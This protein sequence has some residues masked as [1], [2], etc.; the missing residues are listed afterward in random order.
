MRNVPLFSTGMKC[1]LLLGGLFLLTPAFAQTNVNLR[2]MAANLNGDTQSYQP[3]AIRILQGTKADVVA[4]QEFNYTSTNGLGVNTPAAM[5]EMIDTAFG[6]NYSYYREP[7]TG[8]GD[9]PNG[10]ISRYPIIAAGSW[11]D[12]EQTQPNRGFAWAQIDVPGTN[13]LY[14]VSVHLLTST[15][16]HRANESAALKALMQANFPANAWAVVAGDFNAGSRTEA[17]VTTYNGYLTDFPIPVDNNG[18]SLTSGGRSAPHDYVLPSLTLT[19]F[20][21]ATVFPSH[22][23]PTGLVFDS[24]VYT[25]LSDAAPV[26][27]ADS[28][29]AQH[30]AVMKDFLIPAGGTVSTNVIPPAITTQPQGQTNAVGA[31]ITFGVTA[32]G[33]SP[34]AYQWRFGT[35]NISGA[36][37]NPF[38]IANAQLTNNGNYFVVITN[39]AGS[40]TSS[41]A[42]LLTTN[43]PPAITSQPQSQT[44]NLG[45]SASFGV[46]ASGTS[47]L[48]YQWLFGGTNIVGA[49]TNPFVVANVQLTNAGN[50]SVVVS[51]FVGSATSSVA[52]LSVYSTQSVVI[53]Q[54]NFN[55]APADGSLSTG[56]T[57][58]STG[59]GTA[60]LIGGAT[61]TFATGDTTFDPAGSTDNTGWNTATYPAQGTAN[62][63]RGPQFA[64]ST[65][66]RQNIVV[67]WSSEATS[68]GSRY[69]RMQYSTNGTD[70]TDYSVAAT[71]ATTFTV[72]TNG[73]AFVSGANNNANFAV[74][75]MA[76]FESTAA[77][78]A[79]ANYVSGDTTKTYS[80]GGTVRYDMVTISGTPLTAPA[81][82]VLS[83]PVFAGSQPGFSVTGSAGASYIVLVSTNLS[84]PSWVPVLTNVAPFNFSD[85]G[86][87]VTQKFYRAVSQ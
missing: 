62:K 55:S 60:S 40:V 29:Q 27:A 10:I 67:T 65:V 56:S 82:A 68:T 1:L 45:A 33:T 58:P 8:N 74:R 69:S 53:A 77:G 73:L 78:T 70:F 72:K 39:S 36:T 44:A 15:A 16:T 76:E 71:N 64:V 54:W 57:L 31:N 85:T 41:A 5:R 66:G 9:I 30:M 2:I 20:E 84:S 38:V 14:V 75:F 52:A 61:A 11:T 26:Q 47:P 25:P 83:V 86:P 28:G 35:T 48:N 19:N 43:A 80:T 32:T 4:I 21:T 17:C 18:N 12:T 81:A 59:S 46:T 79:N 51:N 50:Y 42:V 13:D 3:F 49:T 22:S 24:N 7:F 87:A 37:T 6:T 23:F 34:L 63:T